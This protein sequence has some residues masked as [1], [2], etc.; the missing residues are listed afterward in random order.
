MKNLNENYSEMKR[1]LKYPFSKDEAK[2][3]CLNVVI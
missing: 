3:L 1:M 2:A